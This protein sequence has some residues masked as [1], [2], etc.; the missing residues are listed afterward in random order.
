MASCR[1]NN[2]KEGDDALQIKHNST[3]CSKLE[4]KGHAST[5]VMLP[6]FAPT[7]GIRAAVGRLPV[8]EEIGISYR[9]QQLDFTS[10]VG[11]LIES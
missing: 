4:G 2:K 10:E 11:A 7:G 9:Y 3:D 6:A 1:L 8:S 5:N